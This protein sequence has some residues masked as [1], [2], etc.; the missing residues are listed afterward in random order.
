[1]TSIK[2]ESEI[3]KLASELRASHSDFYE[4]TIGDWVKQNKPEVDSKWLSDKQIRLLSYHLAECEES[5]IDGMDFEMEISEWQNKQTFTTEWDDAPE[6]A[7][8]FQI[9]KVWFESH[10]DRL[11]V[12][13]YEVLRTEQRPQQ[14]PRVGQVWVCKYDESDY[15]ITL[16]GNIKIDS[17]WVP[18][19]TYM[20]EANQ[21]YY[22]RPLAEFITKFKYLK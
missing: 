6:R 3:E 17:E 21:E 2:L 22:T 18:S 8:E 16:L 19:V 11:N 1:M 14:T 9:R 15:E 5:C 12:I 10:E 20:R 7:T 13:H 4:E